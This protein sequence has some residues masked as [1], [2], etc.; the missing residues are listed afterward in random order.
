MGQKLDIYKS[1][2]LT[3]NFYSFLA[4][5]DFHTI[6]CKESTLLAP[7][8]AATCKSSKCARLSF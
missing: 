7:I 5:M 1:K 6:E 3:V 8:I 2:F 4:C